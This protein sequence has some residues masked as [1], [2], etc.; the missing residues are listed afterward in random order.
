[1][2]VAPGILGLVHNSELEVSKF[3][4]VQDWEVGDTLDVK[5]ISVSLSFLHP[6]APPKKHY[7]KKLLGR[8]RQATLLC[9]RT[10]QW[11]ATCRHSLLLLRTSDKGY[12]WM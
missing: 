8:C 9:A 5:V 6:E 3:G 10:M 11:Q 12:S 4:S 1:M 2:E 7:L